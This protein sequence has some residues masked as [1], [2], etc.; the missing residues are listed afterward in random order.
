MKAAPAARLWAVV[1]IAG[2]LA[3]GALALPRLAAGLAAIPAGPALEAT[4]AGERATASSLDA[5]VGALDRSLAIVP[6]S[7]GFADL[8]LLRWEQARRAGLASPEGA[9][10]ADMSLAALD[11]AIA[12]NPSHPVVWTRRTQIGLVRH[13][14]DD[15]LASDLTLALRTA[16]YDRVVVMPRLEIALIAWSRLDEGQRALVREQVRLAARLD[17]PALARIVRRRFAVGIARE[18]LA[19]DPELEAVFERAYARRS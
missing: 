2:G 7:Q 3:L 16:P 13:G 12:R 11:R 5:A 10:L 15:T 14:I 17:A 4:R 1:G 6:D 18:A 19:Q 8:A 9:A